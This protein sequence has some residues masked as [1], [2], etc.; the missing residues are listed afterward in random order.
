MKKSFSRYADAISHWSDWT[1]LLAY[2]LYALIIGLLIQFVLLPYIFPQWHAGEGMIKGL[3]SFRFHIIAVLQ[4]QKIASQGWQ[5][6]VLAPFG[7]PVAGIASALYTLITPHPWILLPLNAGLHALA[8]WMVFKLLGMILSDRGHAILA[9]LPFLLFPSSLSWVAQMHNDN[10]F[11]T[12]CVLFLYGWVCFARLESW[13]DWRTIVGAGLASL[14]G[15]SLVWLV[16]AY[17]VE[18]LLTVGG[19]LLVILILIFLFRW[20][21]ATWDWKHAIPAIGVVCLVFAL[22]SAFNWV[23]IPAI[24][25]NKEELEQVGLWKRNQEVLQ[26]EKRDTLIERTD[27]GPPSNIWQ[28]SAWLPAWVDDRMRVLSSKRNSAIRAWETNTLRE[29]GSNIDTDVKF[30]N[31]MDIV[32][33]LPR[34]AEISFLAPFPADWF[35]QGSKSPNTMMRRVS[36]IEMVC[37]Y[38]CWPGLLYALWTWRKHPAI[39][40]VLIFCS[41]M[42]IIYTL[43]TPNVGSLYRFRY[44][45]IMPLSGLGLAGWLTLARHLSVRNQS[46]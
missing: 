41:A 10:Y 2:F 16:R 34:A 33:Y 42:M 20:V 27:P 6:W 26:D 7:Q 29:R 1:I 43:G 46:S 14:T 36:G 45:F 35:G 15:S 22:G 8:A 4:S 17:G 28:K 44:A 12:G 23:V 40:V 19:L 21:R 18:M 3:D 9:S 39:W 38:F 37:L 32:R 25:M 24:P 30:T 5:A 13:K 11:V 31:V